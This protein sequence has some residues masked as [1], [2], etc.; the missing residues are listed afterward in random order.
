[1]F[2]QRVLP[3]ASLIRGAA[4]AAVMTLCLPASPAL[5]QSAVGGDIGKQD[6][7]ISGGGE[8]S[9]GSRS[10]SRSREREPSRSERSSHSDRSSRRERGG[11]G[12]GGGGS[13]DGTWASASAGRT[14]TDRTSAVVAISGGNMVSDGFTGHVSGSG[15]VSGV[16]AGSGL[17]ARISGH[18]SGRSGSGTFTR[19]DGCVGTWTLSK[20]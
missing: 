13:F 7:S 18:M 3:V 2:M 16:W 8:D 6:K 9:G 5:S 12:G 4:F 10:T 1:M 20:Q 17:S 14:C 11:G 19:S 15:S